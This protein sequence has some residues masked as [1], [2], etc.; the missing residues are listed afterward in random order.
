MPTGTERPIVT[1]LRDEHG[2]FGFEAAEFG[3]DGVEPCDASLPAGRSTRPHTT[4][5]IPPVHA[6]L[7]SRR[8]SSSGPAAAHT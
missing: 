4:G 2:G 3:I 7:R 1:D 6:L 8:L 5:P